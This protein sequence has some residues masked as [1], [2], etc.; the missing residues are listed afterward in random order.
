MW[1]LL[2][3]LAWAG[4]APNVVLISMDTTRADALSCYGGVWGPVQ[5]E[6]ITTPSLDQLADQGVRFEQFFANA[7]STLTSHTTMLSGLDPHGHG[8]VRNGYE[9]S[10][11]IRTLPQ[12]LADQGWD[13]I[14]VV[15]AAA[16]EAD[17]GLNRGFRV[18]DDHVPVKRGLM[19]QDRANSVV[20]RT[21]SAVDARPDPDQ[22]LFLF[23]HFYDPHTPYEPP[24]DYASRITAFSRAELA[25]VQ[26]DAFRRLV[27]SMRK[28]RAPGDLI[29]RANELYLAEVA[30]M[31]AQ[32][33]RLLQEL[34]QRG[35]LEHALVVAV[36]DHGETLS[37]ESLYAWSH[38][39]NVAYEVM[40]VP[41]I[42][43][44]FGVPLAERA[45]VTRQASMDG[46]ART[47]ERA[48]GLEPTLGSGL[49]F[50]DMVR[51]GPSLDADG[52]PSRPTLPIR[53]EATRP[54]SFEADAGWNNR[55]MARGIWAGGWGAWQV[56]YRER[57]W[58][59]YDAGR[60][61]ENGLLTLFDELL[62]AWDAA[63]PPHREPEM[64]AATREA[65]RALGYV[66]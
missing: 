18:Y 56:P 3:A 48:L 30:F 1:W 31:D 23:V 10:P 16:L 49:D 32:I 61:P 57:P 11:D 65:L 13:T 66:E 20:D 40:R 62:G 41:L 52:W 38:G 19:F 34:E 51:A 43:R 58:Q 9:V 60:T 26:G 33:G 17:M 47:L 53:L 50:Y 54:R 42:L 2:L 8:V 7:P 15:A 14:G 55:L 63:S 36:A 29:Q 44:G 12:R 45:V 21:L 59:F 22:P 35:L 37:D 28:A 39:S 46:L 6:R 27:Q 64:D 24:A 5:G 4:S 25:E